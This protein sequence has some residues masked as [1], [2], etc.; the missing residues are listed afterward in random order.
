MPVFCAYCGKSFTRKEHLERHI[1][2]R[3]HPSSV[4][5]ARWFSLTPCPHQI[6]TSNRIVA[7]HVSSPLLDGKSPSAS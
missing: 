7:A 1:P 2:Q 5:G 4:L 3:E 6:P